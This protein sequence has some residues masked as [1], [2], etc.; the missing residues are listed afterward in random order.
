MLKGKRFIIIIQSPFWERI[1]VIYTFYKSYLYTFF[2]F[3]N[4]FWE[5]ELLYFLLQVASTSFLSVAYRGRSL[6][7]L[8]RNVRSVML[9]WLRMAVIGVGLVAATRAPRTM[10]LFRVTN[11][12]VKN[13]RAS[14]LSCLAWIS[15]PSCFST[16]WQTNSKHCT[17]WTLN[18]T[19][20]DILLLGL[21]IFFCFQ[22]YI[23][24]N[25]KVD[26]TNITEL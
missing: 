26:L 18:R 13:I 3:S 12:S 4:H 25:Y 16:I 11:S 22:F 9:H 19:Y 17:W 21:V 10:A 2:Y 15:L 14:C 1:M 23:L 24:F 5:N 8:H 20:L 6:L 7:D